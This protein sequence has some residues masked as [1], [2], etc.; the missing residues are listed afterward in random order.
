MTTGFRVE[1]RL[2]GSAKFSRWKDKIVFLLQECKLWDIVNNTQTNH[3]MIPTYDTLLAAYTK[4]KIKDKRI[5]LDSIK[6]HVILHVIGKSNAYEM[7][8]SLTKL[9]QSSNEN[10]KMVLREKLKGIKLTKTKNVATY[11]LMGIKSLDST[12]GT[13]PTTEGQLDSA[14]FKDGMVLQILRYD[15][16]IDGLCVFL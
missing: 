7:W 14:T 16:I 12:V 1:D 3:V 9:Y 15:Q 11:M 8:E 5:I 4:N 10:L 2:D 13:K 6:Y